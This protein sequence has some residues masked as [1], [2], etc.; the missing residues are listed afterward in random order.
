MKHQRLVENLFLSFF[1]NFFLKSITNYRDRHRETRKSVP[2]DLC[3]RRRLRDQLGQNTAVDVLG[4]PD[5]ERMNETAAE[6]ALR[7]DE[8]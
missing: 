3:E 2:A 1:L 5:R 8:K 4:L 7:S 6:L